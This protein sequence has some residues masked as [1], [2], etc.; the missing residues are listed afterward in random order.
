[1]YTFQAAVEFLINTMVTGSFLAVLTGELGM[2]DSMTGILSAVGSLGCVFQLL[3]MLVKKVR[4]KP[5]VITLSIVTELL[6]LLLYL[7]PFTTMPRN[8]QQLVFIIAVFL[9]Y[10]CFYLIHPMKINWL[11][12][13]VDDRQRG[14]FTANKEN[15]SLVSGMVFSLLLSALIDKHTAA[16]TIRTACV[17]CAIIMPFL[18]I[19]HTLTLGFTV[20]KPLPKTAKKD[21]WKNIR[22]IFK[23][24][25]V[26]RVTL[27][28][29]MYFLANNCA[30][31]FYATFQLNDLGFSMTMITV[32][33]MITSIV[34]ICFSRFWGRYADHHSFAAAMERSMLI[35]SGAYLAIAF[36]GPKTG[37]VMFGIHAVLTGIAMGGISNSLV[38]LI[39]DYVKPEDRSD[40]FAVC[41][42]VSGVIGFFTTLIASPLVRTFQAGG[43]RFLGLSVYAQQ[44]MS[45]AASVCFI[46][47]VLYVR[48]ALI[49]KHAE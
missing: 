27:V 44:I 1:M 10:F 42:A 34:R 37:I 2:T 24:K 20:E 23:N 16:G 9:A 32:L 46:L 13:L 19:F 26:I 30:V 25:D 14:R 33:G 39:F 45:L 22:K 4:V 35:L 36:A 48:F 38:N 29:S 49:R 31:P 17:I 7:I 11:M 6:F 47:G 28:F 43:N 40:S 21:L 18:I 8:I 3:S 15:L 41:Q 12:S 5:L